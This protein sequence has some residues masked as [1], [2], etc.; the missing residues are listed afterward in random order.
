MGAREDPT[1]RDVEELR[2]L[3]SAS[4]KRMGRRF[5]R[6]VR[7]SRARS[8]ERGIPPRVAPRDA[9]EDVAGEPEPDD[10]QA[11]AGAAS[12]PVVFQP[13][14]G[15]AGR[16]G[17][18]VRPSPGPEPAA[19]PAPSARRPLVIALVAVAFAVALFTMGVWL[20]RS[21]GPAQPVPGPPAVTVPPEATSPAPARA[22]VAP[23]ACLDMA[24]LSDEV[25]AMLTAGRRDERLEVAL[26]QYVAA[27]QDCRA[28]AGG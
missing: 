7:D 18:L 14:P 11:G 1:E 3:F 4:G 12:E 24:R 9:D 15:T 13:A 16:W 10:D 17:Q 5:D 27:S 6:V 28:A 8:A 20:G 26:Q 25:I 22:P 2:E 23:R 21:L 19:A